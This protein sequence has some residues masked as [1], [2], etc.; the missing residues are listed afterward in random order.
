MQ[1]P[2]LQYLDFLINTFFLPF[3]SSSTLIFSFRERNKY[4]WKP[5]NN[6]PF[7]IYFLHS[8]C[9]SS[10]TLSLLHSLYRITHPSLHLYFFFISC[11]ILMPISLPFLIARTCLLI[12]GHF[13]LLP[14]SLCSLQYTYTLPSLLPIHFFHTTTIQTPSPLSLSCPHPTLLPMWIQASFPW[15]DVST[16]QSTPLLWAPGLNISPAFL[17]VRLHR[18]DRLREEGDAG[19]SIAPWLS[20]DPS[21]CSFKYR[22]R[23]SS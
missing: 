18:Q 8:I 20:C 21:S 6:I 9:S 22:I 17:E 5:H 3:C 7:L 16:D 1:V 13:I 11:F 10:L 19:N 2:Y 15:R 23:T 12:F 14:L 4:K